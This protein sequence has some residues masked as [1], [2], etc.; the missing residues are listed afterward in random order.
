MTVQGLNVS[1]VINVTVNLSPTA[2]VF[3]NFGAF[4]AIGSSNVISTGERIREYT[5]L[6]GVEEDF[7]SVAPEYLAAD[8]FFSQNPQPS[9]MYVGRWAQTATPGELDGG[10]LSPTQQ[11]I[12]NFTAVSSGSMFIYIDNVAISLTGVSFTT[13]LNLNGVASLLQ[14]ALQ[15]VAAGTTVVWDAEEQY[16]VIQSGT[17]GVTSTVSYAAP[18]TASGWV[19]FAANPTA[20]SSS[21]VI[22]GTSIAFVSG[23]PVGNQ[24]QVGVDLAH[25]LQN[26]LTFVQGSTDVNLVKMTYALPNVQTGKF[27]IVSQLTGTAGDAYTLVGT[28]TGITVSGATLAGGTG[29]DISAMMNLQSGVASPPVVGIASETPLQAITA[30]DDVAGG[31]WYGSMFAS[32]ALQVADHLAVAGFIEGASTTG[33]LHLYGVTIQNPSVLSSTVTNDLASQLQT[34][35]YE[36][37]C[38]QYSSSSPYAIASLFGRGF[39]VDFDA[40]NS[41]ITLKFK[42]E[43]GVAAELITETQAATLKAKNCNVF[44]KYIN[45]T[46]IIQEGVMAVGYFFDEVMGTDWLRNTC[47][48]NCYNALYTSPTKVP[49]TDPGTHVLVNAVN[50][51][52]VAGVNNGLLAPGQWNAAGFGALNQGDTLSTGFYTYAP[53][54]ATQSQADR[55]ARKS[56]PIQMAAKGSGAIH[57]ANISILFNR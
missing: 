19:N 6:T 51:A 26:L 23:T 45:N 30:L 12:T 5:S 32:T 13:A 8:L 56:V 57:F 17:T 42:Q 35:G 1:D 16:F 21:I 44:V 40:N 46:A 41:V 33:R 28:G 31:A 4:L 27:Y 22:D 37:T 29:T 53:P 36:R 34:L 39:T 50:A 20:G 49:Q 11:L 9:F 15:S 25:T 38:S 47:Q 18:P 54:V 43:P 3:E 55:E 2:A 48:V 52:G 24:V 10:V 14:T 7:G